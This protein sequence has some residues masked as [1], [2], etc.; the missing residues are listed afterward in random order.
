M[1]RHTVAVRKKGVWGFLSLASS[2][3]RRSK[4]R[5]KRQ[6]RSMFSEILSALECAMVNLTVNNWRMGFSDY[7]VDMP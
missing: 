2:P 4:S 5:L 3:E 1:K 6:A 7:S